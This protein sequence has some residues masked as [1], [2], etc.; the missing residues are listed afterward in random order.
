M[1]RRN[2]TDYLVQ[3]GEML[4]TG[5]CVVTSLNATEYAVNVIVVTELSSAPGK[6][7]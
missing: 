6:D 5:K 2:M 7:D 1:N 3:V 4:K